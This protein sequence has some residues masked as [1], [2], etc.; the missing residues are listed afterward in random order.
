MILNDNF[1]RLQ[2]EE[3]MVKFKILARQLPEATVEI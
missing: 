2:E 3:V 1:E